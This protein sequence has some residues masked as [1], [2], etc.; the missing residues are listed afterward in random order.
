[1]KGQ[2]LKGTIQDLLNDRTEQIFAKFK[3]YQERGVRALTLGEIENITKI[4]RAIAD[5]PEDLEK[6]ERLEKILEHIL[7]E[8]EAFSKNCQDLSRGLSTEKIVLIG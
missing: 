6:F 4:S 7:V 5:K 1:M 8:D 3:G 2:E